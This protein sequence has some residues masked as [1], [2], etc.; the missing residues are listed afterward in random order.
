[1]VFVSL[2]SFLDEPN[3]STCM[4]LARAIC[5]EKLGTNVVSIMVTPATLT[6]VKCHAGAVTHSRRKSVSP[7]VNLSTE[8]RFS[9]PMRPQTHVDTQF[10]MYLMDHMFGH[11]WI[12]RKSFCDYQQFRKDMEMI[13]GDCRSFECCGPLR[14][15]VKSPMYKHSRRHSWQ[16]KLTYS[17]THTNIME[18]F[19]NDLLVALNRD[20]QCDNTIRSQALVY[21]FLDITAQRQENAHKLLK[22]F[23]HSDNGNELEPQIACRICLDSLTDTKSSIRLPCQHMFHH[24]CINHWLISSPS[25]PVC[26]CSLKY[27]IC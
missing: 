23:F 17:F 15:T 5:R 8:R 26:R 3:E 24:E 21:S 22:N 1:M 18:E 25:C 27:S 6:A 7:P 2:R 11:K 16:T 12:L 14:R 20:C 4:S 9:L 19:L 10:V 13:M